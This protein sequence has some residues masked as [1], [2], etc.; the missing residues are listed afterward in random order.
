MAQDGRA[1]ITLFQF[2]VDTQIELLL[3][4]QCSERV[5]G[6]QKTVGH[7]AASAKKGFEVKL[8]SGLHVKSKQVQSFSHCRSLQP[9]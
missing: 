1:S 6:L 4:R 5:L 2:Q 3:P 7:I 9:I 8:R